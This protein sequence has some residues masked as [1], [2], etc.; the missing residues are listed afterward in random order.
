MATSWGTFVGDGRIATNV[1][2]MGTLLEEVGY[3]VSKEGPHRGEEP[4]RLKSYL[5]FKSLPRQGEKGKCILMN[6]RASIRVF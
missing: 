1:K 5:P 3:G 4:L 6:W 2:G